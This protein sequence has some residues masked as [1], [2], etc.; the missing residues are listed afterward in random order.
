VPGLQEVLVPGISLPRYPELKMGLPAP[1]LLRRRWTEVRPDIVHI[2]TEGPLGWS[3]LRAARSLGL[4]VASDYRTNFDAYSAH[5]GLG[6]L[7]RP[8]SRWLQHFHRRHR[9]DDGAHPGDA[10]KAPGRGLAAG[11]RRRPRRRHRLVRSCPAQPVASTGLGRRARRPGRLACRKTGARKVPTLL[12]RAFEAVRQVRPD[13]RL[14]LVGDGPARGELER[15]V[16][17]AV[18]C[19]DT[20]AARIWPRITPAATSSSSP[21]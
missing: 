3:A 11:V 18:F 5:Y 10:R 17:D 15:A 6:L 4:P 12:L 9:R 19:P 13:A 2:A 1:R 21:A 7:R 16:P 20:A 8:I 14:V